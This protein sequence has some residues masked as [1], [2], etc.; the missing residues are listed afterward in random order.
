MDL[1]SSV[2]FFVLSTIYWT[3]LRKATPFVFF[4][5]GPWR[6]NVKQWVFQKFFRTYHLL[7]CIV[8]WERIVVEGGR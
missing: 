7:V 6:H 2:F 3:I 1:F 4:P 5:F 8:L